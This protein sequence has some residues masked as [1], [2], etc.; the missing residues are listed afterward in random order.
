MIREVSTHTG[1]SVP[2]LIISA[3]ISAGS[4]RQTMSTRF[5]SCYFYPLEPVITNKLTLDSGDKVVFPPSFDGS[6]V[7]H[8]N[9]R[10]ADGGDI[11]V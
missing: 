8:S 7:S 2:S 5:S 9:K 11:S 6:K 4:L 3:L 1:P 10:A